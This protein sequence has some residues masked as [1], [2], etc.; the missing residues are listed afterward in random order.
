MSMSGASPVATDHREIKS[1]MRN[2][3]WGKVNAKAYDRYRLLS[4]QHGWAQLLSDELSKVPTDNVI[5]EVGSGTGF[6]TEILA[7]SGYEVIGTDLSPHMLDLA[8]RHLEKAGVIDRIRLVL[9]DAESLNVESGRF[10]AVVSRWVL[11]TLPRPRQALSEMVRVLA[12]GGRLVLI[13]GQ[14]L[15]MKRSARWRSILVDMLLSGRK[16]DWQQAAYGRITKSLPCID[17]PEI[18]ETFQ[19]LGLEQVAF[20][21]LSSR[22]GDGRLKNWLM[23]HAWASHVVVGNKPL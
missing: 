17:A 20:R 3:C 2:T 16:S 7:R 11:W 6:I 8:V 15:E 4:R 10:A 9:S 14:H 12:P 5:L 18:A 23:G 1:I 13:D 19:K 21:R 22:E